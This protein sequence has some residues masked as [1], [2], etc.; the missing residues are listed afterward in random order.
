MAFDQFAHAAW[1][2]SSR[3]GNSGG[4]CVELAHAAEVVGIRDS[5]N[6]AGPVLVFGQAELTR[7]L[8]AVKAGR[9]HG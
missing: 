3:S 5:K 2:K 4:Q 8:D 6:Q 1:R 9:L 7:F